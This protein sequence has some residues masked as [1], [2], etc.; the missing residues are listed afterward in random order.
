M[1]GSRVA[2]INYDDRLDGIAEPVASLSPLQQEAFEGALARELTKLEDWAVANR[3]SLPSAIPKL[4]IT[5][6]SQFQNA[7][8]LVH[9]WKGDAGRMEFPA[10]RVAVGEANIMHELAHVYF[11][12][13]NRLLAEGLAVWLQQEIGGNPGYPNFG[14]DLDALIRGKFYA[15][16]GTEVGEIRAASLDQITTP[17]ALTLRIGR[18]TVRTSWSYIIAGSFIKFLVDAHQIGRFQELYLKTPLAPFT[19]DAG[20]PERWNDVYGL[21]I[22]ELERQWKSMISS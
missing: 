8:S 15:E 11:P 3:W 17:T 19:R 20:A 1:A 12:N 7:Q 4:R 13:A 14:D 6:S 22:T 21:S 2:A 5:V 9:C 16:F 10:F 18:R